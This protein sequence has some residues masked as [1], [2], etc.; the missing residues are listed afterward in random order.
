MLNRS[1]RF[2]LYRINQNGQ[3]VEHYTFYPLQK[4]FFQTLLLTNIF[5]IFVRT[6]VKKN[7]KKTYSKPIMLRHFWKQKA[8]F[9][10]KF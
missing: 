9:F 4:S 5:D 1:D 2:G 6:T 3:T 10:L 8:L 7:L